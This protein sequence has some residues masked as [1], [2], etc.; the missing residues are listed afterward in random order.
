MLSIVRML[1]MYN[2]LKVETAILFCIYSG[3]SMSNSN[4][5]TSQINKI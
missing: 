1:G 3:G 2:L 4:A 5:D